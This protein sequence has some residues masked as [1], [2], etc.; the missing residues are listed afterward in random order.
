MDQSSAHGPNHDM[1]MGNNCAKSHR[2]KSHAL[3]RTGSFWAKTPYGSDFLIMVE[4]NR[5]LTEVDFGFELPSQQQHQLPR[6]RCVRNGTIAISESIRLRDELLPMFTAEQNEA[7]REVIA[8][9]DDVHACN[10]FA[11]R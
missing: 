5:S 11:R 8:S 6:R 7:M 2:A 1:R 3:G 10:V 9:N 4:M